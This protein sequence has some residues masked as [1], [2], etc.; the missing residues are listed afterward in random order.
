MAIY[1]DIKFSYQKVNDD[2]ILK[3]LLLRLQN[4]RRF[5]L[6]REKILVVFFF[7]NF[8]LKCCNKVWYV[9]LHYYFSL[10]QTIIISEIVI[11]VAY[12]QLQ[13]HCVYRSIS[14]INSLSTYYSWINWYV[15]Y[16]NYFIM[17]QQSK[18]QYS[19]MSVYGMYWILTS[20]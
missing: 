15:L 6:K 10:L 14:T 13:D 2:W 8:V 3:I 9:S 19:K 5:M 4:I 7:T 18:S 12:H 11:L 1:P 20:A 16:W 17:Y